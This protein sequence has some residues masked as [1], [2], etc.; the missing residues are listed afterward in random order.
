VRD[1]AGVPADA[2]PEQQVEIRGRAEPMLVRA[3][4]NARVLATLVA[5]ERV[6]A[7]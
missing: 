1:A 3:V 5:D 4:V 7:A 2:L 6:A